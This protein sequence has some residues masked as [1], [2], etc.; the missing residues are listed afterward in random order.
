MSQVNMHEAKTRLSQLVEE[1]ASG[2]EP[3]I[4][5]ARNGKPAARLVS[6]GNRVDVSKRI[7]IARGEFAAPE[8]SEE[9][10][11][12]IAIKHSLH[13]KNMPVSGD[14]ALSLFAAAGYEMLPTTA[15]H[16][17]ATERLPDHH[18]DPFDRM[19]VAQAIS[20]PLHLLTH[21]EELEAY[22][23]LVIAV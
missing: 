21:G 22:S 6:I 19:L 3:Q 2:R 10:D 5:I 8:P 17:A 16:A 14:R 12:Q 9:P 23:G 4:M 7:G 11:D 20:E 13:R 1:V 15:T 18:R